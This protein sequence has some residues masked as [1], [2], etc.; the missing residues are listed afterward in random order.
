MGIIK[1]EMTENINEFVSKGDL[2]KSGGITLRKLLIQ[3]YIR[4]RDDSIS[5]LSAQLAFFLLLSLFPFLLFLLTLLSYTP[6]SAFELTENVKMLM[7][8]EAGIF[9]SG[10]IGELL[11]AR[12]PVLLSVSAL[13]TVW[14]ASGGISALSRGLN[15]AYDNEEGRSFIKVKLMSVAFIIGIAL[16][17]II[18]LLFL[19]FG[20]VIGGFLDGLFSYT[21][22]TADFWMLLRYAIPLLITFFIFSMIYIFVPCCNIRFKEALPGAVFSTTGWIITSLVFSVYVNN[23]SDYTKIYGSIGGIVILLIWLYISCVIIILGGEINA[24]FAYFR[25]N[26]KQDKYENRDALP[27]WLKKRFR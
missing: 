20:G 14:S 16:L 19:V 26:L 5:D 1:R 4:Y 10:V 15:K 24:A 7:P 22:E 9:I 17:I 6:L 27:K 13:M 11:K 12:S 3:L 23:L 25:K 18:T 2:L 8:K 21:E